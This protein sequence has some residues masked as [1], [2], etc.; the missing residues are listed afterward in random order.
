MEPKARRPF[1]E[2]LARRDPLLA[3]AAHN[4]IFEAFGDW[5]ARR[6]A[7]IDWHS[8]ILEALPWLALL[9]A[10][11][12]L[13]WAGGLCCLLPLLPLGAYFASAALRRA[14]V[15]SAAMPDSLTRSIAP[16]LKADVF[17][18]LWMTPNPPEVWGEAMIL[19]GR[20]DS[21]TTTLWAWSMVLLPGAIGGPLVAAFSRASGS[22]VLGDLGISAGWV[23]LCLGMMS[24]TYWCLN[25]L[26]AREAQSSFAFLL[27]GRKMRAAWRQLGSST[28][29]LLGILAG[30]AT[31]AVVALLLAGLSWGTVFGPILEWIRGLGDS[32]SLGRTLSERLREHAVP[33]LAGATLAL[34]GALGLALGL[35]LRA[36]TRALEREFVAM[37]GRELPKVAAAILDP[38][39]GGQ[40]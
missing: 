40:G 22:W 26:S 37:V 14:P 36:W 5:K 16:M 33:L 1:P 4:P 17:L 23:L 28:L 39:P 29:L 15:S 2:W 3:G 10:I 21:H 8:S 31:L 11:G 35:V 38:E 13:P 9:L 6:R 24:P 20:R 25:L 34:I 12:L 27:A 7:S 30:T 19:D 32:G 18:D